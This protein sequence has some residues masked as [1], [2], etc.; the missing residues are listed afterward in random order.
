MKMK[1]SEATRQHILETGRKLIAEQGFSSMGLSVL[2]KTAGVP[3]GSFYHYFESKEH[4][5]CVLV[6]QYLDEY[7]RSL[8]ALLATEA[9]SMRE[10]LFQYWHLWENYQH[11]EDASK[12]CLIVKL[13]AEIADISE[14]MRELLAQMT[15]RVEKRLGDIIE[16]GIKDGSMAPKLE[17]R[18][19]A[20]VLYQMWL[21]A[22]LIGKVTRDKKPLQKALEV[23]EIMLPAA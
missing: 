8:D 19:A 18:M 16:A 13:S 6:Q 7:M 17:A 1:K 4:F 21:G 10:K 20:Q 9:L 15:T 12:H 23:T 11:S 2:L 5:G 3:K 14:D 22:S